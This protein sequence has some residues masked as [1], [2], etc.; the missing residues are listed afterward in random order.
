M[1]SSLI[2]HAPHFLAQTVNYRLTLGFAVLFYLSLF[3]V[4]AHAQNRNQARLS[5]ET[6]PA[7]AEVW[8]AISG[9]PPSQYLGDTPVKDW[10]MEAG[11][12]DFLLILNGQDSLSAPGIELRAG[13]HTR[14]SREFA[15]RHASM[16]IASDPDSAEI[17]LD[18]IR[19]GVTPYEHHL[20]LPGRYALLLTSA[21]NEFQPLRSVLEV[22]KGD[23]LELRKQLDYRDKALLSEPL[24]LPPWNLAVELGIRRIKI[25]GVYDSTGKYI[26]FGLD[27]ERVQWNYP[28]HLMLALPYD[29]QAKLVL[30]FKSYDQKDN[31]A[32][33]PSDLNFGLRY[34][35]RPFN[36]GFGAAYSFSL[37]QKAGRESLGHDVVHFNLNTVQSK[38]KIVGQAEAGLAFHLRDNLDRK[39]NPGEELHAY[40]R[41]G[42]L[43]GNV[44]PYLAAQGKYFL[45]DEYDNQP[46]EN[47]ESQIVIPEI[48]LAFYLANRLA[49]EA[50]L[51][52]AVMGTSPQF[53]HWGFH[54]S[55]RWSAAF[56]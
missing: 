14:L 25:S 36:I 33:L 28:V 30:P 31:A 22:Q 13:Q 11:Q 48:G 40:L 43:L 47:S 34:T 27:D 19:I 41:A 45:K 50:G 8:Y 38:G 52:F 46:L 20:L 2:H 24:G 12:Y 23:S 15:K 37:N 17:H 26:A 55:L 3:T 54:L 32:P 56:E 29:L 9:H 1:H 51:P 21:K 6:T 5:V 7:G 4:Q 49:L 39:F 44:L 53:S 10:M 16:R 42:Y 18:G 35:Y